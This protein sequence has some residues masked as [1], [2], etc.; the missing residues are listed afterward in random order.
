MSFD[1]ARFS[2]W[3][4]LEKLTVQYP[5]WGSFSRCTTHCESSLIYLVYGFFADAKYLRIISPILLH[6]AAEA[7]FDVLHYQERPLAHSIVGRHHESL[8]RSLAH[9]P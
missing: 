1:E 2:A 8:L 7:D 4:V 5:I 9:I 3:S 6:C